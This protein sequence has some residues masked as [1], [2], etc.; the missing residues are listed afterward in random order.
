MLISDSCLQ[1]R[2]LVGAN[3]FVIDGAD[4]VAAQ[5]DR[6]LRD[7]LDGYGIAIVGPALTSVCGVA[8]DAAKPMK[9]FAQSVDGTTSQGELPLKRSDE[10][11]RIAPDAKSLG[12]LLAEL[13]TVALSRPSGP[14]ADGQREDAPIV[15][16]SEASR[17]TLEALRRAS[18]RSQLLFFGTSGNSESGGKQA[19]AIGGLLTLA[20]VTA[21]ATAPATIGA[22]SASQAVATN[23]AAG[24]G[25]QFMPVDGWQS[26]G[27]WVD[28]SRGEVRWTGWR[29]G[30][31][32]LLDPER[33]ESVVA[34][35]TTVFD[36]IVLR[37]AD[38]WSIPGPT[39]RP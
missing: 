33:A 14:E 37:K 27:V 35:T 21:I 6:Q 23:V 32:D 10:L 36:P 2:V 28:A 30:G 29:R 34:V 5:G 22:V 19:L 7:F 11:T 26:V 38:Q 13:Q 24:V 39:V 31:Q 1:R 4:R 15:P 3:H 17:T 25:L 20:T 9:T 12:A 16:L 18:G 8:Y